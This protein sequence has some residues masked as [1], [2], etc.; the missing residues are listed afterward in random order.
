VV[1]DAA[2]AALSVVHVG[3]TAVWLGGMVYSLAVVQ[4]RARAFLRDPEEYE[5]F[6]V[7][8]ATGARWKVL[9]LCL[10]LGLSGGGLV[11]VEAAE[12]DGVS[13]LWLALVA[14]KGALLV[15]AAGLFVHV[16][17]RLWP[18]RLMAHVAGSAA[19]PGLQRRF[20]TAALVL[21]AV[22]VAALVLGALANSVR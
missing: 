19:L 7:L 16:S 22:V 3:A 10:A 6:A 5:D 18:A 14:A 9:G 17:W 2:H 21:T 4:P 1:L 12:A 11:A 13:A 15:A 20:R 8:L